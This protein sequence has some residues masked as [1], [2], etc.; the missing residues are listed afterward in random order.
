M[1]WCALSG[2]GASLGIASMSIAIMRSLSRH[3]ERDLDRAA[4]LAGPVAR[5]DHVARIAEREADVAGGE[6]VDVLR[7]MEPPYIGPHLL[8]QRRRAVQ[9][10]GVAA[11][12]V[13]AEIGERGR[14]HLLRRVEDLDAAAVELRGDIRIEDQRQA[15]ARRRM[16]PKRPERAIEHRR[17]V[18]EAGH[19]PQIR[20]AVSIAGIG[21]RGERQ[22]VRIEICQ[23]RQFRLVERQIGAGR[24]LPRH[25]RA[26][27][28]HD[29]VVAGMAGEQLGF[30]H[31]VAVIDIVGDRDAGL[32]GEIRDRVGRD[33]VGPVIDVQPLFL[34]GG[35]ERPKRGENATGKP[36][37]TARRCM[38]RGI[39]QR[40][41][42]L[43]TI[44]R[45]DQFPCSTIFR[46][47]G[48][49]A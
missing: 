25:E 49:V 37:R 11:L 14:Q 4:G 1:K 3:A 46:G 22:H 6:I 38:M 41:T 34:G 23:I 48:R 40:R 16:F 45:P 20:H 12:G 18:A 28:R 10:G 30:E 5:L 44:G 32:L 36:W 15:V 33:V 21:R 29:D 8:Q 47:G 7:R 19:A 43:S 24:D 27:R 13:E 42:G 2:C 9:I 35:T 39:Q 31:L 26:G 17:V